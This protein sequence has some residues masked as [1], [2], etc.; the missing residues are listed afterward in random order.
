[1]N[2]CY[3]LVGPEYGITV[4][5]VYTAGD[6]ALAFHEVEGA[7]GVSPADAPPEF[8]AAEADHA[9]SWYATITGQIWG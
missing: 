3:S 2:T 1:M 8:R 4:A 5:G 7:G 6:A 9:R